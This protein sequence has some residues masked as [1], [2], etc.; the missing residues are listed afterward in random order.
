MEQSRNKDL[1]LREN[2][3]LQ[4]TVLANQSTLLSFLRT[5]LYFTIA[6]LSLHNL[7]KIKNSPYLEIMLILF[8]FCFLFQ[9]QQTFLFIEK[10]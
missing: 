8:Q 3:A 9:K 6:A 1:I 5:S 2:L 10:E 4:R 7:L